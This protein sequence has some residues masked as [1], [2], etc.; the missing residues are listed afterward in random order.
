MSL[1]RH[2]INV[3]LR[4]LACDLHNSLRSGTH[5]N[6]ELLV[7]NICLYR[8]YIYNSIAEISPVS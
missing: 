5:L 8:Y 2:V 4:T 1:Y 7:C 6:I 3:V